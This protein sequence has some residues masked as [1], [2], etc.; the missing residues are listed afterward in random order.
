MCNYAL[1]VSF[2][3]KDTKPVHSGPWVVIELCDSSALL[4]HRF[5]QVQNTAVNTEFVCAL[6]RQAHYWCSDTTMGLKE[7]HSLYSVW[8]N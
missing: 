1:C 2:E 6:K 4:M 5:K 3:D 7:R 8:V